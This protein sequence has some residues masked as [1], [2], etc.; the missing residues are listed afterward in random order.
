M[1]YLLELSYLTHFYHIIE[2][3]WLGNC[4]RKFKPH[5]YR[6]HLNDIFILFKLNN[7]LKYFLLKSSRINAFFLMETEKENKNVEVICKQGKFTTIIHLK[8]TFRSIYSNSE[9]FYLPFKNLSCVNVS[10]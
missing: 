4:L 7:H 2:E 1:H 9:G 8:P 5:F 10:L 3:N 6:R